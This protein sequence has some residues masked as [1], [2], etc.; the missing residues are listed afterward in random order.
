MYGI[1]VWISVAGMKA[2]V[3]VVPQNGRQRQRHLVNGT[4]VPGC[5]DS[6]IWS[7]PV[8]KLGGQSKYDFMFFCVNKRLKHIVCQRNVF[9]L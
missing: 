6:P 2:Y 1:C 8:S 4:K 5:V 7:F 9:E 3:E